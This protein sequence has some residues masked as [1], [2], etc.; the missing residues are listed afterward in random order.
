MAG[1]AAGKTPESSVLELDSDVAHHL[2]TSYGDRA[3]LI[4]KL[5]QEHGM[6]KKLVPHLPI[7]EAEVIYAIQVG[8]CQA[9]T[10]ISVISPTALFIANSH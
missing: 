8:E 7:L 6:G 10:R 2:C 9:E 1:S 3:A 4:L 5:V